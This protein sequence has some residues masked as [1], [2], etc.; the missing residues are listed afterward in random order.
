MHDPATLKYFFQEV[1]CKSGVPSLPQMVVGSQAADQTI[2]AG[3]KIIR[4]GFSKDLRS[5][6][7]SGSYASG[8]AAPTSDIDLYLIFREN[9]TDAH[10][11]DAEG[12][13]LRREAKPSS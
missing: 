3:L 1:D 5:A 7:V 2:E 8:Y 6:Y 13:P 11:M 9:I 12:V 10:G 4:N